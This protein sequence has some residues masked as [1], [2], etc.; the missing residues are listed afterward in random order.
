MKPGLRLITADRQGSLP[1]GRSIASD[2]TA[3]QDDSSQG[4]RKRAGAGSRRSNAGLMSPRGVPASDIAVPSSMQDQQIVTA[5]RVASEDGQMDRAASIASWDFS[6]EVQQQSRSSRAS[7]KDHGRLTL[8]MRQAALIAQH[9]KV[10]CASVVAEVD[11]YLCQVLE[12][13]HLM[14]A[15]CITSPGCSRQQA[16][17]AAVACCTHDVPQPPCNVECDSVG[18]LLLLQ[19]KNEP[20]SPVQPAK[21][22]K[23]APLPRVA[24]LMQ[25]SVKKLIEAVE[26]RSSRSSPASSASS[27][28]R[29]S[30]A[31]VAGSQASDTSHAEVISPPSSRRSSM[32][33]S[34]QRGGSVTVEDVQSDESRL[35]PR[36]RANSDA[37]SVLQSQGSYSTRTSRFKVNMSETGGTSGL[38]QPACKA[39]SQVSAPCGTMHGKFDHLLLQHRHPC[40]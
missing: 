8:A 38:L 22:S 7:S 13:M 33:Q 20:D 30:V 40:L 10:A 34:M 2:E 18:M 21:K 5:G 23:A 37:L 9:A 28:P 36:S 4:K 12:G 16:H 17:Q 3:M 1:V 6:Q 19:A 32:A 24:S 31:A 26:A 27:T 25:G 15:C 39:L 29:T 14:S 35:T 11:C